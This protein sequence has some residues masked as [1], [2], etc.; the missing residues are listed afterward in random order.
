MDP[1][2][3]VARLR[4]VAVQRVWLRAQRADHVRRQDVAPGDTTVQTALSRVILAVHRVVDGQARLQVARRE[5]RLRHVHR[6]VEG[7]DRRLNPEL[8]GPDRLLLAEAV[9]LDHVR[10][11]SRRDAADVE[12]VGLRL[13]VAGVDV[14]AHIE[15][16][17]RDVVR[18]VP[19]VMRVPSD[20]R[21][22]VRVVERERIRTRRR[23]VR[24]AVDVDDLGLERELRRGRLEERHRHD[25]EQVRICADFRDLERVA[26]G[27]HAR[28][29]A[30]RAL[31]VLGRTD[32]VDRAWIADEG[33][34][35]RTEVLVQRA[36]D[37]VGEARPRHRLAVTE[38]VALLQVERVHPAVLGHGEALG[39]LWDELAAGR[40]RLVRIGVQVR[41]GRKL[42]PPRRRPVGDLRVDRVQVARSADLQR[43]AVVNRRRR[44]RSAGEAGSDQKACS[45]REHRDREPK[46]S[47]H[48]TP[49]RELSSRP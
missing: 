36:L 48:V 39:N 40:T 23:H 1:L 43:A 18:A 25:R 19:A 7:A 14:Q 21:L 8:T 49:F 35:R 37:G 20:V 22:V 42:E 5:Q 45:S 9:L 47:V 10:D 13:V 28:H 16:G 30:G 31:V 26:L 4:Q 41:T 15:L 29:V 11:L 46:P 2:H 3:R 12:L 34:A 44:A 33:P 32:D 24:D 27:L 38:L 17:A 6:L